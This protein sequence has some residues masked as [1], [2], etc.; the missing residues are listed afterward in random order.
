MKIGI[1]KGLL[2]SS[3]HPFFQ[4][5]FNELG[6]EIITSPDTNKQIFNLG[7][8]YCVDEACLPIK[9]FHGHVAYL[10]DDCDLLL[11]PRIMRINEKEFICPK[12]CGLPEMV[13]NSIP[14]MPQ[15]TLAPLYA[16]SKDMLS[17]WA[18]ETGRLL[19]TSNSKIQQAFNQAWQEQKDYRTGINDQGKFPLKIALMGHPYNVYDS[20]INMNIIKKLHQAKIGIIT[21]ES[22]SEKVIDGEVQRLYKKPFWTFARNNYGFAAH[23]A[24]TKECS[25]IIYISSFACGIDSVVIELIKDGIGDFP[26]LILKIDEHTGEAGLDT[27]VEA[28]IEMLGRSTSHENNI[29]AYG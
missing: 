6:A 18:E 4:R 9:I 27:R 24:K 14:D 11:V 7:V 16:S 19:T 17:K 28:F 23:V 29:S 12:F 22:V 1:P 15:V 8:K 13:V 26:M 3:Y 20:F 10:K 21:E 5:F 25:G 2:Y